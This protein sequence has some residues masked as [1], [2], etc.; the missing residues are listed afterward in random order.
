M[1]KPANSFLSLSTLREGPRRGLKSLGIPLPPEEYSKEFFGA[2]LIR[3]IVVQALPEPPLDFGNAHC[4]AL[5]II[6]D[7]IA[8]DLAK[9]E[10]S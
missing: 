5:G 1:E 3:R 4:F 9:A 2:R 8:V 7:L 10:V 6:S